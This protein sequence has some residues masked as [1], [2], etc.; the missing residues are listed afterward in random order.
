M[1][2]GTNTVVVLSMQ[3]FLIFGKTGWIGGL[4]GEI[5][6]A[7]GADWEYANARLEDRSAV[8]AELDRVRPA[9]SQ[10]MITALQSMPTWHMAAMERYRLC[11]YVRWTQ[12]SDLCLR[13][14]LLIAPPA[15]AA[16]AKP[17]HV[18]NAAGLTGRPN[19]DWCED[20]KVLFVS[21]TR[22]RR[23]LPLLCLLH[24][25][26]LHQWCSAHSTLMVCTTECLLWA[27]CRLF[28]D[29]GNHIRCERVYLEL[30]AAHHARG[31]L[32]CMSFESDVVVDV[33][34]VVLIVHM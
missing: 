3:K 2:F 24:L 20:H 13:E 8:I 32:S 27:V 19:V 30:C 16:Q 11:I 23:T 22:A 26:P 5:L 31:C 6:T 33:A 4:L 28:R 9:T 1:L 7:Q 34:L 14:G 18:L 10:A 15:S 29:V 21:R 17:T 12:A 25:G